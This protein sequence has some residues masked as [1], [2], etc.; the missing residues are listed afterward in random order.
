MRQLV[1]KGAFD[2]DISYD[3]RTQAAQMAGTIKW[4]LSSS[5]AKPGAVKGSEYTTL[6]P[7]TK[8]NAD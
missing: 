7:I 8:A 6:I 5:D 2:L 1:K 3:V 4:L